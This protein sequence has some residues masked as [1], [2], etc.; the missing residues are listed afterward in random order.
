MENN[1]LSLEKYCKAQKKYNI[2]NLR[3]ILEKYNNIQNKINVINVVGTNGKGSTTMYIAKQLIKQNKKVG[4]F[5]SPTFFLQ[6]ERVQINNFPISDDEIWKIVNFFKYDLEKFKYKLTFFELWTLIAIKYFYDNKVDYAII[7]SGLGG[8]FDSTKVFQNQLAICLTSI[9]KDHTNILGKT[10]RE[11]INQKIGIRWNNKTP[12]F[13][14]PSNLKYNKLFKKYKN[15]K[16]SKTYDKGITNFQ[17]DNIGNIIS[18]FSYLKI[19]L[20]ENI[21]QSTPLFGRFSI[22]KQNPYL[23]LDGAHNFDAIDKLISC[24]KDQNI[25]DLLIFYASS[26]DK[27]YLKIIDKL[28]KNFGKKNI[29]LTDFT[30]YRSWNPF[31]ETQLDDFI[32]I[33]ENKIIE[34]IKNNFNRNILITGSLYFISEIYNLLIKN[35]II[36]K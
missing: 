31:K 20:N 32:K 23:I 35:N 26:Y 29:I 11:I 21:F 16:F 9:S 8:K 13:I 27:N 1:D 33:K 30:Y 34:K 28:S 5:I 3:N 14:S 12:V 18:L 24:L 6:N 36:D 10:I 19:P 25:K 7:E 15:I 4:I 17:K 2:L 22:V